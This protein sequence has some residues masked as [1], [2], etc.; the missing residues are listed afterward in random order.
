VICFIRKKVLPQE[1]NQSTQGLS[2]GPEGHRYDRPNAGVEISG[3]TPA[4]LRPDELCHEPADDH[5]QPDHDG[6]G[7]EGAFASGPAERL[8]GA[9]LDP[10][11]GHE[12]PEASRSGLRP[13][14]GQHLALQLNFEGEA[15]L[16]E[17]RLGL[18]GRPRP[19]PSRK[20]HGLQHAP[21]RR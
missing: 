4:R 19:R 7:E 12:S 10:V 13:N 15:D 18:P 3:F 11:D 14:Y 20:R 5:K 2:A 9:Q 17:G 6:D 8:R 16:A 1:Y 21:P